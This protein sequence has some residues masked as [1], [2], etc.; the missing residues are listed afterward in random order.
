MSGDGARDTGQSLFVTAQ[1]GLRL[2]VRQY[3]MR[4]APGLPVVCL[5]G[6]SG[7][8]PRSLPAMST[9]IDRGCTPLPIPPARRPNPDHIHPLPDCLPPL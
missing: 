3:G 9:L 8:M 4:T 7:P 2:H 1:D 5:P 6:S